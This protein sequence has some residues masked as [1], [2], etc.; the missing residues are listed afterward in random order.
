MQRLPSAQ[1]LRDLLGQLMNAWQDCDIE[2]RFDLFCC[3][4]RQEQLSC[5]AAPTK[6]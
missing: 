5:F 3:Q 6:R 2:V 1:L 4:E